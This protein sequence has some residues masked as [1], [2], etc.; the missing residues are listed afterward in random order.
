MTHSRVALLAAAL[1]IGAGTASAQ[2]IVGPAAGPGPAAPPPGSTGMI[3][4][5]GPTTGPA[6]GPGPSA[7]VPPCM[8]RFLPMRAEAERR[9]GVLQAGINKKKAPPELCQLFRS[10]SEAE[11]KVVNFAAT[12]QT[13]CG[14]PPDA[15]AMMKKNHAKTNEVRDKVC[16]VAA[17]PAQPAGPN[18]GEALGL[19]GLPNAESTRAGTGTLDTLSGNPLAR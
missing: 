17:K 8:Q 10:F 4:G 5:P 19:G 15:V 16:A 14:I 11:A 7:G 18:L 9:A 13:S 2:M 3:V 12:N 6:V 1:L